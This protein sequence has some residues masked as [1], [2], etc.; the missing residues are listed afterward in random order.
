[1]LNVSQYRLKR[2]DVRVD[3]TKNCDAQVALSE[4]PKEPFCSRGIVLPTRAFFW[5]TWCHAAQGNGGSF[6]LRLKVQYTAQPDARKRSTSEYH[7]VLW[8][9]LQM[10]KDCARWAVTRQLLR[11]FEGLFWIIQL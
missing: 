7:R 1:M 11:S 6:P 9:A 3:V 8:G 2:V 5:P 10:I 4:S